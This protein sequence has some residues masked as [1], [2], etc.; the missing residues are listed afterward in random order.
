MSGEGGGVK[1]GAVL[2]NDLRLGLVSVHLVLLLQC[3]EG[4][5]QLHDISAARSSSSVRYSDTP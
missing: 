4:F 5:P 2:T 3:L 1:K